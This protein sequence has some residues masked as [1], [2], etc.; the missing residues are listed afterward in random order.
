MSNGSDLATI[1]RLMA[2]IYEGATHLTTIAVDDAA[3]EGRQAYAFRIREGT[4]YAWLEK[5]GGPGTLV[6]SASLP[7]PGVMRRTRLIKREDLP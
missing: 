6:V 2:A 3:I 4:A 5:D 1:Q 7:E